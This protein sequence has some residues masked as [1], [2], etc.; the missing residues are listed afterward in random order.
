VVFS[1]STELADEI[2]A[3]PPTQSVDSSDTAFFRLQG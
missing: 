1:N 3:I 2:T